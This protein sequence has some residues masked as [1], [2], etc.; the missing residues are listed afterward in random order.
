MPG[1]WPG[2]VE[3]RLRNYKSIP[4][5]AVR[6]T[7]PL[8]IFV[9]PNGA[10]KTNVIDALSL[11]SD[12]MHLQLQTAID[13]HGGIENVRLRKSGA[14]RPPK[15]GLAVHMLVPRKTTDN[16]MEVHYGFEAKA[17]A[18]HGYE[19][20][21]ERCY[22]ESPQGVR[23]NEPAPEGP[24]WFDRRR[25]GTTVRWS[26]DEELRLAERRVEGDALFLPALSGLPPFS[27]VRDMLASVRKYSISPNAVRDLSNPSPGSRLEPDGGNIASV[28]AE[29]E[30]ARRG[31]YERLCEFLGRVVP[32]VV[33]VESAQYGSKRGLKFI[34]Q[35]GQSGKTLTLE[36][37]SMSD[38][39]LRVLGILAAVF[40][41]PRPLVMA[42]EEP[43]AT[44]HPG[45][46]GVLMDILQQRGRPSQVIL[47]THSPEILDTPELS[48]DS[49]RLVQWTDGM[50]IITPM[51]QASV[52]AVQSGLSTVGELH[53]S[54]FLRPPE[55]VV[56]PA[57]ELFPEIRGAVV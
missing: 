54:N 14:K 46:L 12:A 19:I 13:A 15:F 6:F 38:G 34:Q 49:I 20:S 53:R 27:D 47:T 33:R 5:A 2:L 10:G 26:G 44:I 7:D 16:L 36:A 30:R 32:G 45:A 17:V 28:I 1:H 11:L 57:V 24:S 37:S 22:I 8:T 39:T 40:Q 35:I 51:G 56:P 43:E 21:R 3:L 42:V 23:P 9:G 18:D 25:G 31:D 52:A 29:M 41:S 4:G 50:T 55:D 48:P